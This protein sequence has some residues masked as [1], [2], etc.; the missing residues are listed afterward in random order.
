MKICVFGDPRLVHVR[1]VVQGLVERG[2]EVHIV[3]YRP[4]EVPGATVERFEVPRPSVS[5]LRR[6]R[7]RWDQYLR[8]FMHRFDV[9]NVH[10]LHDWGFTPQIMERGCFV[11]W[12]WGSDIVPPPGELTASETLKAARVSMLRHAA[13]VTACGPTFAAA[14]AEFTGIDADDIDLLPLGVDIEQFRPAEPC[15]ID[16]TDG[17]HVG[18]FKGFREVYG[19]TYLVEAVPMV[20]EELPTTRFHFVGDGPQLPECQ[21]LA[22]KYGVESA[23]EWI[24]RQPHHRIPEH[25]AGWDLTV[26][27]SICESFGA[28]ALE[29]SAMSV[30]VVASNVGGLP[31][32]V[33]H[34]ETGLLVPPRDPSRLAGAVVKLLKDSALRRRMGE[35]G[36]RMVVREYDWR[37][38]LGDWQRMYETALDRCSVMV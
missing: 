27:P 33:R 10:F 1:R 28:A 15:S 6:W 7:G 30:P 21:A 16:D 14:V 5:N 11:A 8:S 19:P 20:L 22:H 26:I 32:T 2:L 25:L 18:F 3:C 23:V 37:K 31:E 34:G 38:I 9:V 4:V 24:P 12:P 36:R 29:S 35:A 17:F 13:G